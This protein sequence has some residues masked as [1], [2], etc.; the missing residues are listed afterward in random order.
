MTPGNA[1]GINDGAAAVVLMSQ[2]QAEKKKL[3]PL[4]KI[5]SWATCG[6]DPSLMV[7]DL[8]LRQKKL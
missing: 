6:V 7:Q 2:N 8:Y 4:A 1:S 3:N 5:V